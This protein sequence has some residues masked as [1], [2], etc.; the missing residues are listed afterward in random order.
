[1]ESCLFSAVW[2]GLR[3]LGVSGSGTGKN[4][5]T[6]RVSLLEIQIM[7]PRI[8]GARRIERTLLHTVARSTSVALNGKA[9]KY[10]KELI[11]C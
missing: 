5:K 4:I 1:M 7:E 6:A 11:L 8:I 9:L 10:L 3:L 2:A